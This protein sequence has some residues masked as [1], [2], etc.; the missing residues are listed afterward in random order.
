MKWMEDY[1]SKLATAEQAVALIKSGDKIFTSG[2]A[3]A[4]Y[5]LVNAL[6]QRQDELK[7]V[8]VFNLLLLG[9]D[10]LSKPEM[11][12]HFRRKSLFVGPA[13]REAVN[14]GRADYYPI[15]LYE[16]PGL[17]RAHVQLDVA[18][19]HTSLPDEHGFVSLGVETI[20]AKAAAET[21]KVV[22]AQVNEKM[23]RVLGDCFLHVS[24]LSKIV[25]V[26]EALPT[27]TPKPFS[28][29]E[30]QIARHITTLIDDR[31]TL[32]LGIGG[33]PDAVL[34]LLKGKKDL[35]IHTEMVS[36]G[37]MRAIE[38]GI[39]TNA[40]KSLHPGKVIA[41]FLLGSER[42]YAYS[43]NNPLFELHPVD[44]TND[45]FVVAQNDN[46]VAI[47]SALEVD[48]T[49]QVCS[50][51]IGYTIYSGFGGQVDFIRG[52]ARAKGGKP[53]IALSSTAKNGQLS[54]IVPHLKEG[55]GV[56][57]SRGDVHYVVTEYGIAYLHA[58]N[59]QERARALI[60]IAHP[61]FR[62]EL[63]KFAKAKKYL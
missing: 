32:Q 30:N 18:V 58:R 56:V 15:F 10:P 48:L 27:L 11:R 8:G 7:D 55:A 54:R 25:E 1:K 61:N 36:D 5:V 19:I 14:E 45:P 24:R 9:E 17:F 46:V 59:L 6:A 38:D 49:G 43:H 16:I 22:I 47:N 39:V 63:E 53:I 2:N 42:L 34:A 33:I 57:T 52:A 23:P 21:A 31:A 20:A 41:T 26:S 60:N 29:V 13:D 50:D 37:V 12:G 35:G 3:A 28:D 44:Y 51:S 40:Y 4:P 62:E